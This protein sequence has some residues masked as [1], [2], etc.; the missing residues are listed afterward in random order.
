[1]NRKFDDSIG[2]TGCT[3]CIKSVLFTYSPIHGSEST[4]GSHATRDGYKRVGE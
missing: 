1:M 3:P 4:N 2:I